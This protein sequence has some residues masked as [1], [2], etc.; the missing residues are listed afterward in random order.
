MTYDEIIDAILLFAKRK[1][2]KHPNGEYIIT[3][4]SLIQYFASRYPEVDEI[5]I[6]DAIEEIEYRGY[7]LKYNKET[8]LFDPATFS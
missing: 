7:L 6:R 3:I 5:L 8:L 4:K 1:Q 2:A